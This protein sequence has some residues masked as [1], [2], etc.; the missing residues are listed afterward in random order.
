MKICINNI[1][2][3]SKK[4]LE[5]YTRNLLELATSGCPN[6]K[7]ELEDDKLK[8]MIELF[9]RHPDYLNK[10]GCGI[11]KI[12]VKK[13]IRNTKGSA[14]YI[15][16]IDN[17]IVDISWRICV[18][19]NP[20]TTLSI[21]HEILRN[22]IVNQIVKFK[23]N[24]TSICVCCNLSYPKSETEVDHFGLQFS[25]LVDMFKK[26][27]VLPVS[28][29]DLSCGGH[30]FR[31]DDYILENKWKEFHLEHA[32]LQILCKNCHKAKSKLKRL[33]T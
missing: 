10:T 19:G 23:N 4:E 9:K 17:T 11:S 31:K 15:K 32:K 16:R 29:N 20:K 1:S 6:S 14:V 13:D 28:F 3:K 24:N 26:N 25:D 21:Q 7:I 27:H 33:Q 2:F 22:S 30:S 18:S 5:V 12:I 8:F